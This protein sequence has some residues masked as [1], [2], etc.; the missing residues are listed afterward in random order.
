MANAWRDTSSHPTQIWS[1]SLHI[2]IL[3]WFIQHMKAEDLYALQ[4][5][6]QDYFD[7]Q[8]RKHSIETLIVA[9]KLYDKNFI[10]WWICHWLEEPTTALEN[11]PLCVENEIRLCP[12]Y[13][14]AHVEYCV[15]N[16]LLDIL[17]ATW[18]P[19]AVPKDIMNAVKMFQIN[20]FTVNFLMMRISSHGKD[21]SS[22]RHGFGYTPLANMFW[23]RL[24]NQSDTRRIY[25]SRMV[26]WVRMS[27]IRRYMLPI[28]RKN[29]VP[30]GSTL[31][32]P[33]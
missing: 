11:L 3:C 2:G 18:V 4:I 32:S 1:N 9:D 13:Y 10:K 20:M 6:S 27:R 12:D 28:R 24:D 29:N 22:R 17:R 26:R 21:I 19:E 7:Y 30:C 33:G 5:T 31:F 15:N 14:T 8:T 25:A 16:N 23:T